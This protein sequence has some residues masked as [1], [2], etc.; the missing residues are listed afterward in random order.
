MNFCIHI[1]LSFKCMYTVTA[2]EIFFRVFNRKL[3]YNIT[4]I[5]NNNNNT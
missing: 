4:K 3:E 2:P 5:N 1:G